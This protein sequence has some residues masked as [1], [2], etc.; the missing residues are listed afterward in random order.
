MRREHMPDFNNHKSKQQGGSS[1][2]TAT[3]GC[4]K[5]LHMLA[6][7]LAQKLQTEWDPWPKLP[8]HKSLLCM[9]L[10]AKGKVEA[11]AKCQPQTFP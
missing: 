2:R 1:S 4:G 5:R 3:V 6:L 10:T 9:T 7:K 8:P 11:E